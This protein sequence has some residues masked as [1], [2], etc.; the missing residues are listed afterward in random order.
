MT[1]L[2]APVSGSVQANAKA[3]LNLHLNERDALTV[4]IT[5]VNV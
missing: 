3:H 5:C 2:S 4:L 1:A